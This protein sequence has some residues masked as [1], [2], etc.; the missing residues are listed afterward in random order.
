MA[1]LLVPPGATT[2]PA[3]SIVWTPVD[4]LLQ[5]RAY[6]RLVARAEELDEEA[7]QHTLDGKVRRADYLQWWAGK[8]TA[9]AE[10]L[11]HTATD[12]ALAPLGLVRA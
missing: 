2:Q 4:E 5:W 7:T 11:A 9:R 3:T 1:D 6:S 12:K 10:A 8:F